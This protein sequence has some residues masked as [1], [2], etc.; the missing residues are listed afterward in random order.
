MERL[1]AG[2][3]SALLAFVS[4]LRDVEDPLP[5]PPRVLHSLS[6]VIRCDFA[7]YSELDPLRR[8]SR[9]QVWTEGDEEGTAIGDFPDAFELFWT[10][11]PTHPVCGYRAT[12]G[13]WTTP[14]KASDFVALA[15]FRKTAIYDAAYR[16]EL[17][18]WFDFGLPAETDRTRVFIFARKGAPDFSERDRLVASLVRPHLE[19]RAK[20]AEDAARAADAL[21]TVE[22][23]KG[24]EPQAIVLCSAS[25]IIEFASPRSRRLLKR[26]VGLD[27]GRLPLAMLVEPRLA[28]ADD[29]FRLTIRVA[30]T[31]ELRLLLLEE[32]D[33][34]LERLT[35]REREVLDGVA[36][37]R[38]N[39][40]LALDLGIASATVAKHLEHVFDK[41]GVKTRTAA[42]ALVAGA[43]VERHG[44]SLRG[45]A[46]QGGVDVP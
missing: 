36:R 2:D 22:E 14:L 24:R 27:N 16:G 40:E 34:R 46:R 45:V 44:S 38:T 28:F 33:T 25:G 37:G 7:R 5:F 12:T 42:A 18:H 30:R 13:D 15:D 10:L 1:D 9:L 21:A 8:R 23:A 4:D 32:H 6:E 20:A 3:T 39:S 35:S 17:D 26:Y 31:G 29:D 41:L 43:E 19:A 11:R